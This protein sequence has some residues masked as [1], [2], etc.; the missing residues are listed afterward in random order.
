MK[1][2][3]LVVACLL[4]SAA[5]AAKEILTS[6][7]FYEIDGDYGS[8]IAER[9][10]TVGEARDVSDGDVI[11]AGVIQGT[12]SEWAHTDDRPY[13]GNKAYAV[14]C[15]HDPTITT[16]R[17]E[18][19]FV[20]GWRASADSQ[21]SV[22]FAF[23]LNGVDPIPRVS[24][25]TNDAGSGWIAQLHGEGLPFALAWQGYTQANLDPSRGITEPGY[26]LRVGAKYHVPDPKNPGSYLNK[27]PWAN[28][29]RVTPGVWNRVMIQI[30][31]GK[32]NGRCVGDTGNGAIGT[33]AIYT[34]ARMD[35]ATGQW[36]VPLQYPFPVG[37]PDYEAGQRLGNEIYV[38]G[39]NTGQ[40]LKHDH[41]DYNFKIGQYVVLKTNRLDYD[42]I[43]YGKR[44][45]NIT[46]NHLI[47][48]QKS[49]LRLPFEETNARTF[50]N[51]F[52]RL[53]EDRSYTWSLNAV[54]RIKDYD[55]DGA[56]VGR[57]VKRI[58][59]GVNGRALRFPGTPENYVK[60]PIG[61][62]TVDDFD[63]G[64][65][66]TVSAWFRTSATPADNRGLVMIDEFSDTWKLLL[67]MRGNGIAFGVRHRVDPGRPGIYSRLDHEF[68]MGQ[69]A[70]TTGW[71]LVTGT[72]NRFAPGCP[73][74]VASPGG[75]ASVPRKCE[76]IKLYI[77][78]KKVMGAEGSDL[79]I[80][81][82]EKKLVV[83]KYSE[84]GFFEGDIDDVG[85]F[86]YTMTAA[87]VEELYRKRGGR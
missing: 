15:R 85:L 60:V 75:F 26:Y 87:Q 82:G 49:V 39:E 55:N 5:A 73:G 34:I 16:H 67:Y 23:R 25:I 40:C 57:D 12:C 7:W 22:S 27:E 70:G 19:H 8:E 6:E 37:H 29:G 64:N 74:T 9:N 41:Q 58:D 21:R 53:V 56:I 10:N 63:V 78:G 65:Y 24:P 11:T 79:P 72:F 42:N 59:D 52:G 35:N 71:H 84:R 32:G 46:K 47:G 4:L 80:L 18:H 31:L 43:S 33:D 17:S 45:I 2:A 68:P 3:L 38:D 13:M 44:W 36:G 50:N 86:N 83:G 48:Y 76:R 51:L 20:Q 69:Y 62:G 61:Q 81:R 28:I 66:M 14:F 77:D 54:D 30:D 1:R